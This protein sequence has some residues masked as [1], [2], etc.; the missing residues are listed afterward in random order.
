[1]KSPYAETP[2][3]PA[4]SSAGTVYIGLKFPPE[5]LLTVHQ[6][7][8]PSRNRQTKEMVRIN[9]LLVKECAHLTLN[10]SLNKAY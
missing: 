1:M 4:K 5:P 6:L 3:V 9:K 8:G 7:A 10:E 2:M